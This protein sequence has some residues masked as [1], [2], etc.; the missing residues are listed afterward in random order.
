MSVSSL[1][2]SV[3]Y[4]FIVMFLL[5]LYFGS[6]LSV[7]KKILRTSSEMTSGSEMWNTHCVMNSSLWSVENVRSRSHSFFLADFKT[8][9]V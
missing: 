7:L 4:C 1:T 2:S 5:K 6:M 9:R 8:A 3:T